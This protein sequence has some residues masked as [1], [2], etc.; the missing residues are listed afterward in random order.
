MKQ[1][2]QTGGIA[3]R[4]L[5]GIR[6]V[7]VGVWHAGPGASAILGDLGAEIIKI[8]S[9]SGDP[10]RYFGTFGALPPIEADIPNWTLLF[11]I[12][13]R[14]KKGICLD[15]DT[16][17]G[18]AIL[19]ALVKEAD[20]FVT[21]LRQSTKPKIGID[22]ASLAKVN[23]KLIYANVSG[24]GPVGPMS[25]V[26]G[27]DP[28]GQAISGMSFMT[29]AEEPTLLQTIILDQLTAIA[30]SHAILTA[31][32]TR[33]RQG[34][35]QEVQVSLY[36]TATWLLHANLL[37]SSLLKQTAQVRWDRSRNPPLRNMFKCQDGKWIMGANHP[38]HKYWPTFCEAV[39]E[40][41]LAVDPRFATPEL[42]KANMPEL[43]ARLDGLFA[44]KP[45]KEWLEIL[46]AAGLL[47]APIQQ[48]ADVVDD[49]QALTNGYMVDFEHRALGKIRVP[50]YPIRFSAHE[51]GTHGP[52][53]ELG[54]HTDSVLAALGYT[55]RD[56][57]RLRD[58]KVIR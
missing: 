21:N 25:D 3:P 5:E 51:V 42:R 9:L 31:L 23:P 10:E 18:Q 40:K 57:G 45:Q 36:G 58:E 53:P 11:E 35:G 8:E 19:H 13:N 43:I 39:G 4:P 33:E 30:A 20:I 55:E 6:I 49:P 1:D 47:F 16:E 50:G 56:I 24:F 46:L 44:K 52:A 37:C 12:T 14:N 27:F 48:L 34:I 17:A 28:L 32:V 15:I 29:G 41:E 7:E 38:E 2:R 54:E 22:Y 26:G